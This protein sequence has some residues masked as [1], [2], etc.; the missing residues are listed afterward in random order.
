MSYKILKH[1]DKSY[2]VQHPDGSKFLVAKKGLSQPI[3]DKIQS[4]YAGGV[5]LTPQESEGGLVDPNEGRAPAST[6]VYDTPAPETASPESQEQPAQPTVEPPSTPQMPVDPYTMAAYVERRG[7][8]DAEA[9]AVGEQGDAQASEAQQA[10]LDLRDAHSLANKKE[11]E[12]LSRRA[13]LTKEIADTKID[14]GRFWNQLPTG[15]KILASLSVVLGGIG[16]G[17]KSNMALDVLKDRVKDDIND[18][19]AN[20]HTKKTLLSETFNETKDL[21]QALAITTD[22]ILTALKVKTQE[23]ASKT[24]NP[25]MAARA[26]Q[27]NGLLDQ[28]LGMNLQHQ[29]AIAAQGE[30]LS[31]GVPVGSPAYKAALGNKELAAK[32]VPVGGVAHFAY[33]PEE[34][35]KVR[36]MQAIEPVIRDLVGQLSAIGPSAVKSGTPENTKAEALKALLIPKLNEF[37]NLTRLTHEDIEILS[38]QMSDPT[39][40]KSL[41]A[42]NI[43]NKGLIDTMNKAMDS[44]YKAVL[45]SYKGSVR[46]LAT[47]NFKR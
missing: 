21:N 6:L 30:M 5:A 11:Q 42:N 10:Q 24:Q 23:I 47:P 26:Q 25:L 12:V 4:F 9:K 38:K 37:N 39:K 28:E 29:K 31:G 19:L 13:N 35:E 27:L 3:L 17:G 43:A 2:T 14:S 1:D 15:N 45:P 18:Q 36:K 16:G 34:A 8:N 46:S 40:F 41:F 44:E 22:K 32:M 33:K 7:A 20:L